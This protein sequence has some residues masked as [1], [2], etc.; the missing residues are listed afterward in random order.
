[1]LQI[2][3]KNAYLKRLM[4]RSSIH[5]TQKWIVAKYTHEKY[6]NDIYIGI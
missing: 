3:E 4:I 1:M 5:I 6:G 2:L